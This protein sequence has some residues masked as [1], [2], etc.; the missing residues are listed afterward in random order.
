MRFSPAWADWINQSPHQI[1]GPY[2]IGVQSIDHERT[3]EPGISDVPRERFDVSLIVLSEP[4]LDVT[5]ISDFVVTEASDN[6]G[7]SLM[8]KAL[9]SNMPRALLRRS[10]TLNHIIQ[11]G[12][13]YPQEQ[14]GSAIATLSGDLVIVAAQ[15]FQQYS[16]DD[17]LGTPAVTNPLSSGEIHTNVVRKGDQF[18]VKIQCTRQNIS[19]DQWAALTNRLGDVALEDVSGHALTTVSPVTIHS[20]NQAPGSQSFQA[21]GLFEAKSP[22]GPRR[23][24]WNFPKSVKAVKVSVTFHD[25][26]MP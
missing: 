23:L 15:D 9:A 2:W 8:P 18:E 10:E 12:L 19:D 21:T 1:V 4:K 22:G 17:V 25:L 5:H 7:H 20:L 3:M 16:V 24:T 11:F 26:K 6:A 13:T 14:P